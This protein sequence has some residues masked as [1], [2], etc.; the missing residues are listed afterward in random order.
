MTFGGMGKATRADARVRTLVDL[1][2][3]TLVLDQAS[4]L[5][6]ATYG[7]AAPPTPPGCAAVARGRRAGVSG[8]RASLPGQVDE[9]ERL[10][11]RSKRAGSATK[12]WLGLRRLCFVLA[13]MQGGGPGPQCVPGKGHEAHPRPLR[14]RTPHGLRFLIRNRFYTTSNTRRRQR[15]TPFRTGA[16]PAPRR[17]AGGRRRRVPAVGG[18]AAPRQR[19]GDAA[20][21][22]DFAVHFSRKFY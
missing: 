8:R 17:P 6:A 7:C 15:A 12:K 9:L 13:E 14:L 4:V 18:A 16:A 19:R 20:T 2:G 1:A 22:A 3:K 11:G 5:F 21:V 10:G